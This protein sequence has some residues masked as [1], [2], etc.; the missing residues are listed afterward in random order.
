MLTVQ[1]PEAPETPDGPIEEPPTPNEA[2][3]EDPPDNGGAPTKEP[4][5]GP[6]EVDPPVNDPRVPG[7]PTRKQVD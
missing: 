6:D 4:P 7:Q 2:P 5:V 1:Q 3:I